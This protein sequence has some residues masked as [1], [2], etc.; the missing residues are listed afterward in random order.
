[1]R[2]QPKGASRFL[3]ILFPLLEAASCPHFTRL[4]TSARTSPGCPPFTR[5]LGLAQG[6]PS[7]KPAPSSSQSYPVRFSSSVSTA[8]RPSLHSSTGSVCPSV[9]LSQAAASSVRKGSSYLVPQHLAQSWWPGADSPNQLAEHVSGLCFLTFTLGLNVLFLVIDGDRE[10]PQPFPFRGGRTQPRLPQKGPALT[11]TH[12]RKYTDLYHV[13]PKKPS[14]LANVST[15]LL[16]TGH[17]KSFLPP[18]GLPR[19]SCSSSC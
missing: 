9:R 16:P 1:M 10:A 19:S 7:G 17:A 8:P 2:L 15:L 6:H 18:Q 12:L 11:D 13:R 4:P 5:P 14:F 3:L